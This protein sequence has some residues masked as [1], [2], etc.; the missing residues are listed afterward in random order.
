MR[1]EDAS[2]EPTDAPADLKFAL[3]FGD[4][5]ENF[6]LVRIRPASDQE[7]VRIFAGE[8]SRIDMERDPLALVLA[9]ALEPR[10]LA[11]FLSGVKIYQ[12]KRRVAGIGSY[13]DH[14]I[15]LIQG[16]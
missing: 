6:E 16:V 1:A 8:L 5:F 7:I 3:G 14:S 13:D 4:L 12:C 15:F 10:L 9:G 11:Y 2:L